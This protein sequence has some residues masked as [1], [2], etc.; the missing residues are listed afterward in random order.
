MRGITVNKKKIEG[1]AD[2]TKRYEEVKEEE[3]KKKKSK[4]VPQNQ[5]PFLFQKPLFKNSGI[6]VNSLPKTKQLNPETNAGAET[7]TQKAKKKKTKTRYD[8]IRGRGEGEEEE[9]NDLTWK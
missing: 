9:E 5:Q 7:V 4:I 8:T 2:D 1:K 6:P 3:K